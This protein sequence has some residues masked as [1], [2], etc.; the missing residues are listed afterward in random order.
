MNENKKNEILALAWLAVSVLVLLSLLTYT[1]ND[2]PF[3]VSIVNNPAQN[4]FGIFGA[5]LAWSLFL[6]FGKPAFFLV[7]VFLFW[8]L[9]KW[10]G[11]KGQHLWLRIFSF[12]V[13]L[14]SSCALF[15]LVASSS[16]IMRFQAGGILGHF[17][18]LF[19]TNLLGR[20]AI[21]IALCLFILS[22][23]LATEL[24][25]LQIA[26]SLF[27][28]SKD[29]IVPAISKKEEREDKK[30]KVLAEKAAEGLGRRPI[31]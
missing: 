8:A 9:A 30:P 11:K 31:P 4:F 7:P 21:F 1:P 10:A 27:Q 13:F 20:G 28:K 22:I 19:L 14:F 23:A 3:E 26:S 17:A 15:S 2:I 16:E 29:M 6:F 18:S 12:V 24:L 5:S 25:V